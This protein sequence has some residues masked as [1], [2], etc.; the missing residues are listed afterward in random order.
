MATPA[1]YT[2]VRCEDCRRLPVIDFRDQNFTMSRTGPGQYHIHNEGNGKMVDVSKWG[3]C[4]GDKLAE[5]FR[6]GDLKNGGTFTIIENVIL[7]YSK[8]KNL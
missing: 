8:A 3:G 5:L 1:S 2:V 4:L 7:I 6:R